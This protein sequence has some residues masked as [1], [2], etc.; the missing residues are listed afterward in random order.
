MPFLE[1]AWMLEAMKAKGWAP[2]EGRRK[3]SEETGIE[4]KRICEYIDGRR[5]P[6][7]EKAKLMAKV[8]GVSWTL[9]YEDQAS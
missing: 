5:R 6:R 8:L 1:R 7:P 3:L 2:R 4:Y 9:F